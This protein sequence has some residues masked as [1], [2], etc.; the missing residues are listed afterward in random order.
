M[1]S[2]TARVRPETLLEGPM[3]Y[4]P[5]NEMG[6]VFLFSHLAKRWRLRIDEIKTGFPDCIVY[7]KSHGKEKRIAIEFEFKSK[8]FVRHRHDA[9]QCDWIV[10]WEHNWPDAATL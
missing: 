4:A 1:K 9:K 10:C 2:K 3:H 5:E 6:V 8:N 7:Q